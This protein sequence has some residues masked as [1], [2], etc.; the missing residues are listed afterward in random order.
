MVF[1]D[2]K[3]AINGEP[4]WMT[5]QALE[6]DPTAPWWARFVE[7][8]LSNQ[9][10][11]ASILIAQTSVCVWLG[12]YAI[13]VGIPAHLSQIQTGYE[14]LGAMHDAASKTIAESVKEVAKTNDDNLKRMIENNKEQI[15]N[16]RDVIREMR[17]DRQMLPMK[18]APNPNEAGGS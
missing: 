15:S 2:R 4:R 3:D 1:S 13:T 10:I 8:I 18:P 14:K 6:N 5:D 7:W 16:M 11:A 9:G 17:S 12:H